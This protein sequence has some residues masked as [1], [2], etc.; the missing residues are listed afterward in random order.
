MHG[1]VEEPGS[2]VIT[3]SD[4]IYYLANLHDVHRGMPEYFRKT[5][6]PQSTLMFLGYN[7]ED[8]N[9]Q[10]IWEGVLS[11]YAQQ[12]LRKEAYALVM[13]STHF[14]RKYWSRKNVDIFDQ[15]LTEFAVQLAEHF[16]LEVPQ[17]GR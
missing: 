10:V 2:M 11:G 9:F 5:M 8:W 3:Q 15:D 7:L 16:N 17:L 14:Q 13:G 4:Y 6:I 1:T 12:A